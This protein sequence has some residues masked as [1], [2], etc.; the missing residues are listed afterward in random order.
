MVGKAQKSHGTRS[1]VYGGCSNGFHR[2]TFSKSNAELKGHTVGRSWRLLFGAGGRSV[3]CL[4]VRCV[5]GR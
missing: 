1:G 2:S 3:G 5:R 4:G